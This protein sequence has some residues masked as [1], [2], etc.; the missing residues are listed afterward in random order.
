MARHACEVKE[1]FKPAF[2][3]IF[4]A[5]GRGRSILQYDYHK[6]EVRVASMIEEFRNVTPSL[7]D[8]AQAKLAS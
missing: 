4:A 7:K 3:L 8:L 6:A 1:A 5:E 2:N